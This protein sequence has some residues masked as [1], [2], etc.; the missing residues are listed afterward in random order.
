MSL[1]HVKRRN[2]LAS[3]MVRFWFQHM[4]GQDIFPKFSKKVANI[5]DYHHFVFT[6]DAKSIVKC[7][8]DCDNEPMSINILRKGKDSNDWK[9]Q[10]PTI[11]TPT[12]FNLE[13]QQYL[14]DEIREFCKEGTEDLVA[15]PPPHPPYQATNE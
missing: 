14:Y 10:L 3:M 6:S 12:G 11:I 8:V 4:I 5:T 1:D 7:S 2:L 15:L 13:R 9:F